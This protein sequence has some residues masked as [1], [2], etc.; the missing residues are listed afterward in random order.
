MTKQNTVLSHTQ[1]SASE[2]CARAERKP[3]LATRHLT[4][5][6]NTGKKLSFGI[7]EVGEDNLMENI[8]L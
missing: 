4:S 7:L 5:S 1:R 3:P 6:I 2:G 8:S